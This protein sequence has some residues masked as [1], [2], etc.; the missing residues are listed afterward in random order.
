MTSQR[1]FLFS[2]P[3]EM[4]GLLDFL[5]VLSLFLGIQPSRNIKKSY[6]SILE[7]TAVPKFGTFPPNRIVSIFSLG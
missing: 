5:F 4:D 3:E 2:F 6:I 1:Y 7:Y